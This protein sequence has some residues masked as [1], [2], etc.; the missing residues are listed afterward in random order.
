M[1][2][3]YASLKYSPIHPYGRHRHCDLR[4]EVSV[5]GRYSPGPVIEMQSGKL[6][7]EVQILLLIYSRPWL[8][9]EK[10]TE[11]HQKIGTISLLNSITSMHSFQGKCRNF[12]LFQNMGHMHQDIQCLVKQFHYYK[13]Y[14]TD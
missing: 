10:V 6:C 9:S 5:R 4:L 7:S 8:F 14:N 1:V 12:F 11:V 13:Y 2:F 3:S